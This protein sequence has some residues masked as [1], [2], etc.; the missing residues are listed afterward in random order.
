MLTGLVQYMLYML[1]RLFTP[2]D[3]LVY[4][5]EGGHPVSVD[6]NVLN[7][8]YLRMHIHTPAN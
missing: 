5:I 8:D 4:S 6:T 1:A 2:F 7:S 3:A